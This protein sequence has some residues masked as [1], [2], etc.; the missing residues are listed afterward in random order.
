L[1]LI[2]YGHGAE[3]GQGE[4]QG[5]QPLVGG[6]GLRWWMAAS[7]QKKRHKHPIA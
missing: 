7:G 6:G 3:M 1:Y 5:W 2:L 4:A